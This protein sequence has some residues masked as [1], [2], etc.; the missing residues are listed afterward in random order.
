M[1]TPIKKLFALCT[2]AA[3]S[4]FYASPASADSPGTLTV[5]LDQPG[6]PLSPT[7]Y[8]LMTEE[9][10]HSYDGGLYAELIQN[11]TF[12]DPMPGSQRRGQP[13]HWSLVTPDRAK[14][15]IALDSND[16]LSPALPTS[17]HLEITALADGQAPAPQTTASGGFPPDPTPN[18]PRPSMP[19]PPPH[20]QARSPSISNQ[21]TEPP[22]SPP[23]PS[24]SS[25]RA[26][27]NIR[28]PSPPARS[29][30]LS[31]IASSSLL[32]QKAPSG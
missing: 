16:P 10:N 17:L 25:P 15:T 3:A 4:L 23:V 12:K 24:R 21:Q 31:T 2:L 22:P 19:A 14:A 28:S 5:H 1:N 9:I 32:P 8:G 6:I 7:F 13:P 30:P 11:R 26:G 29:P 18:T 27:K 20:L